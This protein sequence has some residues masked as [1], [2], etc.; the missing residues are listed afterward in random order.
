MNMYCAILL[1]KYLLK[2]A[3][4]MTAVSQ[5]KSYYFSSGREH[6]DWYAVAETLGF[7]ISRC[8]T[9]FWLLRRA[10]DVVETD[11]ISVQE[12]TTFEAEEPKCGWVQCGA[13][14]KWRSLPSTVDISTLPDFW[15]CKMNFHNK[16]FNTCG[17]PQE[18]YD[19]SAFYVENEVCIFC[20]LDDAI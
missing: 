13:C 17:A 19:Q 6:T 8:K 16:K 20:V 9:K 4:L 7:T 2:E 12:L 10:A 18:M 11:H 14:Q 1:I 5:C 3:R 15:M